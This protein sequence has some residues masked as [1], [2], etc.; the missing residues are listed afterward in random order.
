MLD[1]ANPRATHNAIA[2]A[3]G[4]PTLPFKSSLRRI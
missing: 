1:L 2:E 4:E 3:L